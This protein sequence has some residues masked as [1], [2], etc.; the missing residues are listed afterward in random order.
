MG[1]KIILMLCLILLTSCTN[2]S[3]NNNA[4]AQKSVSIQNSEA[5]KSISTLNSATMNI[6][7]EHRRVERIS[8]N[9]T[10]KFVE[11]NVNE[12]NDLDYAKLR[13]EEYIELKDG[14]VD[15]LPFMNRIAPNVKYLKIDTGSGSFTKEHIEDLT[16]IN[17]Y[18][19]DAVEIYAPEGF[20]D[21]SF[22]DRYSYV[23]LSFDSEKNKFPRSAEDY[24]L[25]GDII[26]YTKYIKD[27]MVY[28]LIDSNETYKGEYDTYIKSKML[29]SKIIDD[30]GDQVKFELVQT[31]EPER[32]F[33]WTSEAFYL[34]D[35]N[36]DG[37]D[38]IVIQIGHQGGKGTI[39]YSGYLYDN[40]EYM[41]NQSFSE[42]P[43][44]SIDKENKKLH[45]W[46]RNSAS[47]MSEWIVEYKD[48]EFREISELSWVLD[49]EDNLIVRIDGG[50][51]VVVDN[52]DER[53]YEWLRDYEFENFSVVDDFATK[54]T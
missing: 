14:F 21:I 29:V 33:E 39:M 27:G 7:K 35:V 30:E 2:N 13:N 22:I 11:K 8:E 52:Y 17:Q 38:D 31:I 5:K 36:F 43:Y 48:G 12:L 10:A 15:L 3:E 19:L 9:F 40:G 44:L 4:V 42:F 1:K 49:N 51:P 53:W 37:Y 32:F 24:G 25:K 6:F 23:S 28:E 46:V 18:H 26:S 47:G 54:T 41:H 45:S 20:E 50:E 34:E 16:Q